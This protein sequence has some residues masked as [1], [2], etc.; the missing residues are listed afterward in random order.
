MRQVA[1]CR[2]LLLVFV[3]AL[4]VLDLSIQHKPWLVVQS[5]GSG[6]LKE[7]LYMV[8][9]S[10]TSCSRGGM[11]RYPRTRRRKPYNL[12]IRNASGRW[13]ETV[14]SFLEM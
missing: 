10:L 5:L 11:R 6:A 3:P 12:M 14:N 13:G 8:G 1:V 9:E 2:C 4:H 7:A